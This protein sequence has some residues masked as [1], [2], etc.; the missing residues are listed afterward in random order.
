M[1]FATAAL[2]NEHE[3]VHVQR[4]YCQIEACQYSRIGFT[5]RNALTAHTRKLHNQS[6]VLLIP[7]KVRR[8]TDRS[9]T[10][11]SELALQ[12]QTTDES[13]K[14]MSEEQQRATAT[15]VTDKQQRRKDYMIINQLAKKLMDNCKEEV[16]LKFEADVRAWPEDKKQQ[17][18]AQGVN[19]LFLRFRQHADMLY[20]RGAFKQQGAAQDAGAMQGAAQPNR[21]QNQQINISQRQRQRQPNQEFDFTEIANRQ[22]EAMR[23]QDQGNSVLP[24]SNIPNDGVQHEVWMNDIPR[25]TV[26]NELQQQEQYGC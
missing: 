6:N 19:P 3:T 4:V 11:A 22:M 13:A 17:L 9:P 14:I 20:R 24:A 23:S 8:T 1:G 18:L 2:R 25:Q 12:A 26:V 10:P 5:K 15:K 7:A 16:R 21:M